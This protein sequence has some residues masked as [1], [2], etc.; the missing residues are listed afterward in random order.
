MISVDR[1]THS[2]FTTDRYNTVLTDVSFTLEPSSWT[3]LIGPS[4]CGKTTMLNILSGL[5]A[6]VR[7][8]VTLGGEAVTGP[9]ARVGYMLQHDYLFPWRTVGANVEL[10]LRL[11]QTTPQE[12]KRRAEEALDAVGLLAV[13]H[14]M[15]HELSGGMRQR[16]ALARTLVTDPDVVLLDEPFSALDYGTKL[17]LEDYVSEKLRELGKTVVLVTH[18]IEEAICMCDRILGFHPAQKGIQNEWTVDTALQ[19]ISPFEARQ[20][21]MMRPLFQQIWKELFTRENERTD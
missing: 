19:K 18:D 5:T 11:S 2:F 3:A 10:P 16:V 9:S 13:K 8:A 6:P 7:G 1:I 12:R 4:G 17:E 21:P 15:P 14:Q 20:H